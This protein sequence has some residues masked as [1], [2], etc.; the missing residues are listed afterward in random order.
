VSDSLPPT[1]SSPPPGPDA[2]S[3]GA[4]SG[5]RDD[6]WSVGWLVLLALPVFVVYLGANSIWDANEAFYVETPRQMVVGGDYV[7]PRFNDLDRVN[8]PVLSYWMVAGLYQL[9]GVS[10]AVE[11]LGIAL[12]ALGMLVAAFLIGRAIRSTTTGLVAVVIMATAPRVV[13]HSRR[14]FI[15]VYVTLFMS[16]T[17]ACFVLAERYPHHRRRFLLAMY[18]C[19]GLG[20]LTKG[21]VALVLPGLVAAAWFTSEHRWPDVRRMSLV[22]GAL[23]V[24]AIVAPWYGA[25]YARHGWD[26]VVGFFMGENVDR[27]LSS[28]V[29]GDSR[30]IWFY[31]PVLLSDL[32]PWAPLLL[33][34]LASAWRRQ[35]H[36]Q[37]GDATALRRLLWWWVVCITAVFSL[38]ET[39]QDLYILPVMVAV[40][41]LVA[42]ALVAS[43]FGRHHRGVRLLLAVGALL[44]LASAPAV[45]VLFGSG[46][47]ALDGAGLVAIVL[48]VGSAVA[49]AFVVRARERMAFAA[50]ALTFVVFNY[51][52]VGRVLP[53]WERFKP[54]PAFAASVERWG[55]PDDRIGSY[56]FMLPS[57]VYYT[58]R[59][60][61]ELATVDQV[62][63]FY[64]AG[65]GWVMMTPARYE[66]V[67][68][69][70]AGL[71]VVH[72]HQVFGGRL[73]EV[74]VG[75]RVEVFLVANRCGTS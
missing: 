29:P 59:T 36:G 10:V 70:V 15:D 3:P 5:R 42:D 4:T 39:K 47:Y 43:G 54:T 61:H 62:R 44:S 17:L 22:A 12:G 21:P 64:A 67:A 51:V 33:V 26:P 55:E 74:L 48:A 49:L 73:E 14:I 35:G 34:P 27:Y 6:R 58:G 28:M 45:Y 25:L 32:F 65:P 11:R 71:C 57:L 18:V 19:I 1:S 60:V 7:T 31:I 9:F 41:V 68:S 13:M 69:E 50:L 37:G 63:D 52:F 46:A 53:S 24:L 38:S 30:P 56:H 16:L 8:K 75:E 20:V 72:R 66:E 2:A 23:I 40:A